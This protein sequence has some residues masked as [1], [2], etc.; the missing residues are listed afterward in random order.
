GI[1]RYPDMQL[2]AIEVFYPNDPGSSF[3]IEYNGGNNISLYEMPENKLVAN[4]DTSI[5]KDYMLNFKLASFENYKTGLSEATEDSI[6]NSV[7]FQ[8]IKVKDANQVCEIKLWTQKP[9]QESYD[10]E[11]NL[12]LMDGE[13]VYATCND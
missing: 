7:P 9:S 6:A 10:D 4:F 1:L 13:R 5:V 2:E 12:E 11:G 3:K 8:S